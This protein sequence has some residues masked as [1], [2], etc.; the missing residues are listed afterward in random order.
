MP[1]KGSQNLT[2]GA[3]ITSLMGAPNSSRTAPAMAQTQVLTRWDNFTS[4]RA[5]GSSGGST[6]AS[7]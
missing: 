3:L 1:A 4:A 6:T 2:S 5:S 7:S